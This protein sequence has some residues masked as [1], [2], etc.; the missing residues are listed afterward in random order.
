MQKTK[1]ILVD[2]EQHAIDLFKKVLE[3]FDN[4]IEIIG[5]ANNLPNALQLIEKSKPDVVFMDIE[6]PKYSGLQLQDFVNETRNFEIIYVTAH[7]EYAI[8]A[9]RL[10]A[11]DYLLKPIDIDQL[12]KCLLRL[13]QR[14]QN[15]KLN[16]SQSNESLENNSKLAINTHNG[17]H[18]IDIASIYYIEASAMY[19]IIHLEKEQI[20]VSKPLKEFSF[21]EI[22]NFLRTHRSFIVN[23]D[24]IVRLSSKEGTEVE[25]T[26]GRRIPLSSGR[27]DEFKSNME[28]LKK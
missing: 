15:K 17:I 19:S 7:N 20:I 24:K 28:A 23:L 13:D 22:R 25:L 5:E 10:E 8:E 12:K 6:M 4:K 2:D 3:L 16:H 27:K 11:F 9:I 26:D 21:L 1:A 14:L 18:Y